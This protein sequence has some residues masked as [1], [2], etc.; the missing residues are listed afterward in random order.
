[1]FLLLGCSIFLDEKSFEITD[2]RLTIVLWSITYPAKI[3]TT[4]PPS[5]YTFH[6]STKAPQ[7]FILASTGAKISGRNGRAGL[8]VLGG[9][10]CE[11]CEVCRVCDCNDEMDVW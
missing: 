4:F 5:P 10:V 9:N 8:G 7:R 3:S 11:G 6:I 1:M 2:E